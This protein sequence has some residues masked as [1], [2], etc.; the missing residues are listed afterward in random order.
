AHA[1]VLPRLLRCH[2]LACDVVAHAG[3]LACQRISP[4]AAAGG[5]ENHTVAGAHAHIVDFGGQWLPRAVLANQPFFRARAGPTAKDA[6]RLR[7]VAIVVNRDL[8]VLEKQINLFDAV[9]AAVL[10]GAAGVGDAGVVLDEHRVVGLEIFA[11]NVLE[12]RPPGVSVH[13]VTYRSAG[14]AAIEYFHE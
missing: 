14:D 7:Q 2:Q 11:R 3:R 10:T 13:P 1:V 6:P 9:A 4:S 12:E 5:A 8:T